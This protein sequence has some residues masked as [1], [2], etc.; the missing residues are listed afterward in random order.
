MTLKIHVT[1]VI[2]ETLGANKVDLSQNLGLRMRVR[3][4]IINVF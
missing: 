4:G 1:Q 2:L 3:S